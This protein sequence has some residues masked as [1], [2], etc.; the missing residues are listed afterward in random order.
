MS[1]MFVDSNSTSYTDVLA[2]SSN[3]STH[4][5]QPNILDSYEWLVRDLTTT[6]HN[7]VTHELSVIISHKQLKIASI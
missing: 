5:D 3:S 7:N 4:A 2:P 1:A 6:T